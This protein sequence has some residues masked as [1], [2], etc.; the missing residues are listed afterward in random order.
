MNKLS[1]AEVMSLSPEERIKYNR[2]KTAERVARHRAN[3]RE[4]ALE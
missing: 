4:H 1:R 3:N 2:A